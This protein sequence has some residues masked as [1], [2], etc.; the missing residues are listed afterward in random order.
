MGGGF[1]KKTVVFSVQRTK[2]PKLVTSGDIFNL[3]GS[4]LT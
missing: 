4:K 1:G 2:T 3:N